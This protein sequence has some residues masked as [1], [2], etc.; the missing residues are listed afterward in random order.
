MDREAIEQHHLP[1]FQFTIHGPVLI[2][3]A[4]I[5]RGRKGHVPTQRQ[6]MRPRVFGQVGSGDEA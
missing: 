6:I 2:V 5:E 4:R 3:V 1:G